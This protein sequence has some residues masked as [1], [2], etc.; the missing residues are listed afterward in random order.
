MRKRGNPKKAI[1]LISKTRKIYKTTKAKGRKDINS[2]NRQIYFPTKK[3]LKLKQ[4][5][6]TKDFFSMN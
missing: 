6:K 3:S 1:N 4:T 2:F 5:Q